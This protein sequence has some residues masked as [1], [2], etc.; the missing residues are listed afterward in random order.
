MLSAPV[1]YINIFVTYNIWAKNSI[2]GL[3]MSFFA[4]T[5]TG[6]LHTRLTCNDE[7][8]LTTGLITSEKVVMRSFWC[9]CGQQWLVLGKP[10]G[11]LHETRDP[12]HFHFEI[13]SSKVPVQV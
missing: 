10:F 3:R 9:K 1:I 13:L 2:L 4:F 7:A 8:D 11:D 6:A 5:L 12:P